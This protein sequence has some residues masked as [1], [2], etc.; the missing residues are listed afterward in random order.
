MDP[1]GFARIYRILQAVRTLLTRVQ[2]HLIPSPRFLFTFPLSNSTRYSP[3]SFF[4]IA[5]A[6]AHASR[7]GVKA[8]GPVRCKITI[9]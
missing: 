5:V 7:G 9:T 4:C 8:K 2:D 3:K 1:I 6:I